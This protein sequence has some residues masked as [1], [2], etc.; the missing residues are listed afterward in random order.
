MPH[1]ATYKNIKTPTQVVNLI[2][3]SSRICPSRKYTRSAS[4]KKLTCKFHQGRFEQGRKTNQKSTPP[5]RF[6]HSISRRSSDRRAQ[7]PKHPP[8]I[9]LNPL[10]SRIRPLERNTW[11]RCQAAKGG[12]RGGAVN[13]NGSGRPIAGRG[14]VNPFAR[15]LMERSP[16]I[17]ARNNNVWPGVINH[18]SAP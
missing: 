11:K 5:P 3:Q 1:S 4:L 15:G 8:P 9:F 16:G 13:L 12:R 18:F 2:Y 7:F 6:S 14:T 10:E 17:A